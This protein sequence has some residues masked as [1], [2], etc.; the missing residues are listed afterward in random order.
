M[1]SDVEIAS[2]VIEHLLPYLQR[3]ARIGLV[4]PR[5]LYPS[6]AW[7]KSFDRFPTLLDEVNR[8]VRLRAIEEQEAKTCRWFEPVPVG[9]L[10]LYL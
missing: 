4:A 9:G 10:N 2:G 7:Q 5:I 6:G 8:F 3:D 1:D